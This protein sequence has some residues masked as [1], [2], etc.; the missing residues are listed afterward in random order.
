MILGAMDQNLW[1]YEVFRSC[2]GKA[3]MCW[4]QPTRNDH[5]AKSREQ[6]E[7]KIQKENKQKKT[8]QA[9]TRWLPAD[10]G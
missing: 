10:P 9:L 3:G 7:K 5:S 4:S 8:S 1:V 2:L 6:E